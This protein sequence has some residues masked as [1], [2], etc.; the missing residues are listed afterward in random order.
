VVVVNWFLT[1]GVVDGDDDA[2]H[3]MT[4]D[5]K[6][7]VDEVAKLFGGLDILAL[8]VLHAKDGKDYIIEVN[9][10][11][12]GLMWEH[13]EEDLGY[14]RDLVLKRMSEAYD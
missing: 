14:I 6:L 11:A 10:T 4:A 12:P 7:W 1:D 9:D 8:D 3:E 2:D 5:Y 13:E